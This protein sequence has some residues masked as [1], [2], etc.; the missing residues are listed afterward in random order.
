MLDRLLDGESLTEQE[1][2]ALMN[3]LADGDMAPALAGAIFA[4][5]GKRIRTLFAGT[6][7]A[8]RHQASWDGRDDDGRLLP[9][10][11]PAP[12]ASTLEELAKVVEALPS[13]VEALPNAERCTVL[14]VM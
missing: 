6:A 9:P 4:A 2:Y 1:A 10:P 12:V 13:I 8:G 14:F 5:T 3:K 11:P 7:R